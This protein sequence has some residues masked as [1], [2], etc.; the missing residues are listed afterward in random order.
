MTSW[1]IR[2]RSIRY[3]RT[4]GSW[5]LKRTKLLLIFVILQGK[6][7]SP[8]KGCNLFS[9]TRKSIQSQDKIVS[10]E[11]KY[12][13]DRSLTFAITPATRTTY[14]SSLSASSH[15]GLL[16]SSSRLIALYINCRRLLAE[17]QLKHFASRRALRR[18]LR[19]RN[20]VVVRPSFTSETK[21]VKTQNCYYFYITNRSRQMCAPPNFPSLNTHAS[22]IS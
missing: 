11:P 20:V 22:T 8:E 2:R 12:F 21:Q 15:F 4:G 3:R 7:T 5:C 16:P 13:F 9:M 10:C 17:V 1:S 18:H 19:L 14:I 6:G